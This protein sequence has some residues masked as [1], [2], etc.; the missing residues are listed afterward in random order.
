M[1]ENKKLA[2]AREEPGT[3]AFPSSRFPV[4][5]L[6]GCFNAWQQVVRTSGHP[7]EGQWMIYGG[8]TRARLADAEI[9]CSGHFA[10]GAAPTNRASTVDMTIG[11]YTYKGVVRKIH[12]FLVEHPEYALP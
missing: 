4:R 1:L 11:S 10:P 5:Y 3:L 12:P 6:S 8:M 2:R 9:L 7:V